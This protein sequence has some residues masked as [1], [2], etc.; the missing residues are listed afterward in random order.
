[1]KSKPIIG[2]KRKFCFRK[3]STSS[4]VVGSGGVDSCGAAGTHFGKVAARFRVE[5]A[6][7]RRF[8]RT[9]HGRFLLYCTQALLFSHCTYYRIFLLYDVLRV[10]FNLTTLKEVKR[11]CCLVVEPPGEARGKAAVAAR[12]S[13]RKRSALFR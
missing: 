10:L 11:D 2:L 13:Y 12:R 9:T 8:G 3:H 7:D 4:V 6:C 5:N 1:M